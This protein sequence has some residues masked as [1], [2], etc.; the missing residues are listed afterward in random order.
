MVNR[1][2]LEAIAA[3]VLDV[4]PDA[5]E[6]E[7]KSAYREKAK[8]WH[9]DTSDAPDAE[10]KFKAAGEARDILLGDVNFRDYENLEFRREVMER[11]LSESDVSEIEEEK[12]GSSTVSTGSGKRK[13]PGSFDIGGLGGLSGEEYREVAEQIVLGVE[14]MIVY[15]ST[16][17]LYRGTYSER[18]FFNDVNEYTEGRDLDSL[19]AN[20]YYL[21]TNDGLRENVNKKTFTATFDSIDRN[22]EDQY[23]EGTTLRQVA[24]VLAT[25]IING[26]I[27]IGFAG[28]FVGDSRFGSD[29][30]FSSRDSRFSRGDSRFGGGSSS[31]GRFG[32][33]DR[34]D[35]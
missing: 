27:D 16:S 28:K 25:F 35:R 1:S 21:A 33:D 15:N 18:D 26:G 32:R 30:R 13:R 2:L 9:P 17:H 23:V 34:F 11:V 22:L 29:S 10:E 20:D 4:D 19:G 31:G 24:E 3:E 8:S 14:T 6:S 7:V 5:D 12:G